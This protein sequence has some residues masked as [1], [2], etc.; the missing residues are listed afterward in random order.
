[1]IY[2]LM[3]D[4][5]NAVSDYRSVINLDNHTAAIIDARQYLNRPYVD[6]IE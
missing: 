3:G 6:S 4:R 5:K 1:M 2:D